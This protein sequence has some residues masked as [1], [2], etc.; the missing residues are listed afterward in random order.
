MANSNG[1]KMPFLEIV[2]TE[3]GILVHFGLES[4]SN[5]LKSKFRTS[6]IA[7]NDIFGPF[8]FAKTV[9]HVKME[10]RK[11]DLISTNSRLNFTF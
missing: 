8:E 10:W 11:Y 1:P 9:I 5:L 2:E 4:C 7:K 3:L 6:K